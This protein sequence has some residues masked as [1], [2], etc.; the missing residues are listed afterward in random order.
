MLELAAPRLVLA[1]DDSRLGQL[2][3]GANLVE[4]AGHDRFEV[5]EEVRR[6]GHEVAHAGAQR[7]DQQ[8]LVVQAGHENGRD[9]VSRRL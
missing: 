3:L 8:V 1:G 6:L 2:A 4:H 7:L 9:V 5:V